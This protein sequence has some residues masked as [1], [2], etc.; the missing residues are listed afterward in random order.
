M[1]RAFAGRLPVELSADRRMAARV[2]RLGW[3]SLFAL[4]LVWWLA[5]ISLAAAP[6]VLW[7]LAAGWALMPTTLFASLAWPRLRYALVLP[8]SLVS[9]GLLAILVWWF[10]TDPMA[11]AGWA[12]LTVGVLLGGGMGL[13]FWFRIGPVPAALDDPYAPGRWAL[14][15]L[16]IGLIVAGWGLAALSF[17]LGR[18]G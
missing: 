12:L 6:W 4:G 15:G 16:H 3:V 17:V 5:A 14:I 2:Q 13:W 1:A 11:A 7:M 18:S 9:V 10:P 8:A